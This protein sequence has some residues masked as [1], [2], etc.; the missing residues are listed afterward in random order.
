MNVDSFSNTKLSPQEVQLIVDEYGETSAN[1]FFNEI[2]PK[3]RFKTIKF[4]YFYKFKK[5][6]KN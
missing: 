3:K 4:S 5:M 2:K 1:R 6:G